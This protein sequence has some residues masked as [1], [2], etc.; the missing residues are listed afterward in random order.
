MGFMSKQLFSRNIGIDL[1]TATVLVFVEG[2]G[3]VLN[4]PS[5]VA[6]DNT[7]DCMSVCLV[8]GAAP[9]TYPAY[10]DKL[11]AVCVTGEN[12]INS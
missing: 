5:V 4:E 11:S 9:L 8:V 3:I 6:V 2:K 7:M 1:G 10:R 12:Q